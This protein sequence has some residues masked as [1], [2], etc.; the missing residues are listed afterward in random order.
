MYTLRNRTGNPWH[1]LKG[2]G[3]TCAFGHL[4]QVYHFQILC[5]EILATSDLHISAVLMGG[6][7]RLKKTQ[8]NTSCMGAAQEI[9]KASQRYVFL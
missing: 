7:L 8:K 3:G 5:E 6:D 1:V 9:V 4:G 2:P